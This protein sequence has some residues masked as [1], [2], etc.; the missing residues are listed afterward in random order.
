M[1]DS[2]E[3]ILMASMALRTDKL[4]CSDP[5][6][7]IAVIWIRCDDVLKKLICGKKREELREKSLPRGSEAD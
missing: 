4:S 5:F 7:P 6:P 1:P 3:N 2:A